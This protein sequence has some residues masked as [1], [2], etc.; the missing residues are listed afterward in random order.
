M[1]ISD[2]LIVPGVEIR[3]LAN[4]HFDCGVRHG[5]ENFPG[6]PRRFDA[7]AA[8]GA[9][10]FAVAEEMIFEA[11]ERGQ[12]IIVAPAGE[13]ELPPVIVIGGL[14]AHRDHG[15]D[16]GAAADHLAAGVGQRA[17]VQAGFRLGPN[18]QSE[19]GLPIANR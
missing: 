1:K 5:V 16:R 11:L 10:M 12:H 18:I 15:V 2:A 7:P 9:V 4:P 3:N 13:P 17:A 6:Q 14:T 19:R 8:A